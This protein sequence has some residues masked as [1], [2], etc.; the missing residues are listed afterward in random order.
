M[1]KLTNI[2]VVAFDYGGT[3]DLPGLHWFSFL[4]E[5]VQT[6]LTGDITVTREEFWDAYVFGERELEKHPI[7][8]T[9]GLFENLLFKSRYEMDYLAKHILSLT[10]D[11]KERLALKLTEA[12]TTSIT[13][14]TYAES[15]EVLSKLYG[16]YQLFIVSNYYGNLKTV[17]QEADFLRFI[18]VL[19]DSTLVGLRKPDPAIWQL[20]IDSACVPAEQILVVGD[21][22]KNDIAPAM[23][24]GCQTA[25]LTKNPDEDYNGIVIG[26]LSELLDIL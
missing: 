9:T 25:W 10:N 20:A 6:K 14:G 22:M 4:W 1:K 3:L 8:T 26:T 2:K 21:S 7:P 12:A 19:I 24:L 23:S 18:D 15:R 5:L 13:E 17:L 16:K 11:D